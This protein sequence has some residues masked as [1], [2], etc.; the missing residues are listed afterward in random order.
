MKKIFLL[1]FIAIVACNDSSKKTEQN[2]NQTD[3]AVSKSIVN[4]LDDSIIGD[5]NDKENFISSCMV[6]AGAWAGLDKEKKEAFCEC[7]WEKLKGYYP[8]QTI[9]DT[10]KL[11]GDEKLKDC[12]NTIQ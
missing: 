8:G 12:L 11:K 6:D 2:D 1:G 3:T 9:T 7:I 10:M 5:A 4:D